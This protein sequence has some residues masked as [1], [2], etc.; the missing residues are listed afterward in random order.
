MLIQ[1]GNKIHSVLCTML[2][3][4][5]WI[6]LKNENLTQGVLGFCNYSL[7]E[8]FQDFQ[9]QSP[10]CFHA[11]LKLF[12][13]VSSLHVTVSFLQFFSTFTFI[14]R[15]R[16][17]VKDCC[18]GGKGKELNY[19]LRAISS[20]HCS[21]YY[22]WCLWYSFIVCI[23]YRRDTFVLKD[24]NW[25]VSQIYVCTCQAA[26]LVTCSGS[27]CP[28]AWWKTFA[29]ISLFKKEMYEANSSWKLCIAS[30]RCYVVRII[31]SKLTFTVLK[32]ICAWS[33]HLLCMVLPVLPAFYQEYLRLVHYL[34]HNWDT[35]LSSPSLKFF[36]L[37]IF[38][39][40][41]D[42][43][44]IP[45]EKQNFSVERF[46]WSLLYK[47][48]YYWMQENSREDASNSVWFFVVAVVFLF[49]FFSKP[50]FVNKWIW[51][52]SQFHHHRDRW[53]KSTE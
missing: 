8:H 5:C 48:L 9:S 36:F 10:H 49:L 22:C 37:W 45:F 13:P 4:L 53:N 3:L 15:V 21:L 25:S 40:M 47:Y 29:K 43:F 51:K 35:C 30:K 26:G 28:N 32:G 20:P 19:L 42:L 16:I 44:C 12:T 33:K 18:G 14:F 2:V 52:Y 41:C 6:V 38:L 46:F 11:A 34:G 7:Q 31:F 17:S 1:P 27:G 24:G 23:L 39:G 50:Q